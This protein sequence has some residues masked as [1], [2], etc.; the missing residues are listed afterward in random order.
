MNT[1]W[2]TI[3]QYNAATWPIQILLVIAAV[4]VLYLLVKRPSRSST[5][6]AKSY[7]IL[8][9]VWIAVAYYAIYCAERSYSILISIYWGILALAW[10]CLLYTSRCV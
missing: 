6:I 2:N 3:A 7:L 5:I 8:L 4:V 1:F 10:I 9:Y